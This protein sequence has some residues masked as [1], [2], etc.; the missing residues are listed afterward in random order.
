MK[1]VAIQAFGP[2]EGLAVIDIP[3][4]TPA[5]GQVLIA[6]EAMGVG[7]SDAV[8]RRG[9]LTGYG[10]KEGH[11]PG[12]EVAGT[13]AAVGDGVDASWVGRRVWAF[14]G[15]NGGYVEQAI[16]A[17]EEILPLPAG[18]SAVDAVTLGSSGIVA[19]FALSHAHFAPGESV[20]VRGAAGSLGI[21]TVQLAAHGGAGAVAVTT[22]SA[23][24]GDRLRKL[25]ATHVLDR[26]GEGGDAAPSG[27]APS[28]YDVIIDI[29][30]GAD[31]PSFFAKLN[32]NG[33]MV[34]VGAVGGMP[35]ADFGMAM[36]AAF[37][38]SMSFAAF[39]AATV[40]EPDRRAVRT[41]QFAA[42]SRGELH[43]VVHELLPLEQAVLAH[44]KMDTGE[45][46]GRIVLTP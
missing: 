27:D 1:A 23:E 39:S 8:I 13:V 31:M 24:R 19:H 7:G 37:Q 42:A 22:S 12:S 33:R 35:P 18:L 26:S 34:A 4:P 3:V 14:T 46:F 25:G 32:P 41:E 30:A 40:A 5:A 38:K 2:P 17:V 43:T 29:I 44:R 9:T 10:F 21:M 11:I 6:N 45:V 20:L 16:A 36:M 28:G 15:V